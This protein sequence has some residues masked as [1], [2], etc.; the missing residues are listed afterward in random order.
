MK[1]LNHNLFLVLIFCFLSGLNQAQIRSGKII[2]ERKTNLEKEFKNEDDE[3]FKDYIRKNK[4]KIDEFVLIFNDT[5]SIFKP[6][7]TDVVD[8]LDWATTHNTTYQNYTDSTTLM[9]LNLWSNEAFIQ[10]SLQHRVWKI[11][12]SKRMIGQFECRKAIYEKNDSTRL[13]AWYSS[14]VLSNAG[15][16]G[17]WGLPGTILGLATEDGGIVY[18]AKSVEV[19]TPVE[20]DFYIETKRKK[21]FTFEQLRMKLLEDYGSEPWG[22]ELIADIFRWL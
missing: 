12:D 14:E 17:F 3:D 1:K 2:F 6:V 21:I 19:Y 4:F 5:C 9:I 10:D 18:F 11:T 8:D 22:R 15:P 7:E 20:K 16:E 13:Y